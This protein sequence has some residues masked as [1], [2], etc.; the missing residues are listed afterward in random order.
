MSAKQTED[1]KDPRFPWTARQRRRMKGM[2]KSRK[3]T[4]HE[5]KS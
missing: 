4:R 5:R 2:R 1:K 3:V